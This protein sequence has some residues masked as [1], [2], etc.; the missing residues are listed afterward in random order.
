MAGK[1]AVL[2]WETIPAKGPGS[3][4]FTLGED[5]AL[6]V[7]GLI[8]P[9]ADPPTVRPQ[10]SW[11]PRIGRNATMLIYR[12]GSPLKRWNRKIQ[13]LRRRMSNLARVL[14]DKGRSSRVAF[15]WKKEGA[16]APTSKGL[17]C[18]SG[19]LVVG[20]GPHLS[21]SL[22]QS[23][24]GHPGPPPDPLGLALATELDAG[25]LGAVDGKVNSVT[26]TNITST[27]AKRPLME[28]TP[29]SSEPRSFSGHTE[30]S[31]T[32]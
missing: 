30:L 32:A 14:H 16:G 10:P 24:P 19:D 27:A 21:E 15:L 5:A 4:R 8:G 9:D 31:N 28:I 7:A 22:T 17:D 23:G 29:L 3:C 12:P 18:A 26:V 11:S 20:P 6:I 25:A 13:E 1:R 2:S